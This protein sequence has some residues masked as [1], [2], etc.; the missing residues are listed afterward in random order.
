MTIYGYARVS[1]T[2][3]SNDVQVEQ[4]RLAGA[5]NIIQEKQSAKNLER[6]KLTLLLEMLGEGDTLIV[7]KLDR[8]SR[9]TVD[10]LNLINSLSDRKVQFK[11]LDI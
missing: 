11:A 8:L 5:T 1:S 3:Q 9:N 2:D 7:T 10:T 4:L 6:D